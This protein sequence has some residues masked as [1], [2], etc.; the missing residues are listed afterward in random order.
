[1]RIMVVERQKKGFTGKTLLTKMN[2]SY[3]VTLPQN[4]IWEYLTATHDGTVSDDKRNS[5][6]G[7]LSTRQHFD[8]WFRWINLDMSLSNMFPK[9]VETY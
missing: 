1:M 3:N 2:F 5:V 8:F 6:V 4:T 9:M 7:A